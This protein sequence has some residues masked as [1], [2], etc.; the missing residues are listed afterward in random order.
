MLPVIEAHRGDSTNAPENTLAAFAGALGLGVPWIELDV[1][2]AKDGTLVV[3]HD[4]T[5]DRTTH[6]I[7]AVCDLTAHELRRLDA[8][9]RF[10]PQFVGARIP[11]LVEV[12]DL[13]VPTDTV[14]NVEIKSSLPGMNVPGSVVQLL[15]R[16]GRE[17]QYVVSSFELLP[18]LQV[19]EIAPEI[20]LA[21]I[22]DGPEILPLARQHHLPW[23]H[24]KASTVDAEFV[25]LAHAHGIR[26][27]VWVVDDPE[28]LTYWRALGVDKLCTNR[29]GI[30]LAAARM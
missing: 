30:M 13:I 5:V 21:L 8:G 18:L 29:P 28:R 3:I 9:A 23:V 4:D 25:A 16:Y 2:P 24:G 15:R 17:R 10:G 11:L 1:H 12:L 14:L 6:G 7:G 27:N 19:R 26:V 22:G 20:A